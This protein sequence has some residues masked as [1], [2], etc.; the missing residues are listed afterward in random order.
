MFLGQR[1]SNRLPH[2]PRM[3]TDDPGPALNSPPDEASA[4]AGQPPVLRS[5]SGEGGPT[6]NCDS[7]PLV[8]SFDAALAL[9]ERDKD[10]FHLAAFMIRLWLG[11]LVLDA[12]AEYA[13]KK[14]AS[15]RSLQNGEA[16]RQLQQIFPTILA[17]P[18]PPVL[19]S[20]SAEG[21]S[22]LNSLPRHT[23]AA[24]AQLPY[25][26]SC[27]HRFCEADKSPLNSLRRAY[28]PLSIELNQGPAHSDSASHQ[29]ITPLLH[30]SNLLRRWCSWLDADIHLRTHRHWH[31]APV[32]F[33][34]DAEKREL[35]RL[36]NAQRHFTELSE[37][38][39]SA[40]HQLFAEAAE[41]F[42]NSPKWPTLGSAMA[43]GADPLWL[44]PDADTLIISLWPLVTRHNWTYRDLLNVIRPAL[45]RP[46]AYPSDNERDF[47]TYCRNVLG[48]QKT[49]RGNSSRDGR[50]RGWDVAQ[51]LISA[52][53]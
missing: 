52:L 26:A 13:E 6:I 3:K 1:M 25:L 2:N 27:F 29:S 50:P 35:A 9:Y 30:H 4:K 47:S 22:T 11:G 36:G 44:Y 15:D 18:Q 7:L 21:G 5:A 17:H 39:R 12:E 40:W 38:S 51:R 45:K 49:G 46:D 23:G 41:R 10:P 53:L 43:D 32:C 28:L 42:K 19:R 37:K 48:L 34:P 20:A 8:A 31:L 24:A 16:W 33:D 14:R